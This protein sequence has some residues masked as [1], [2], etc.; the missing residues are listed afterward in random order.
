MIVRKVVLLLL[1]IVALL[2]AGGKTYSPR[3]WERLINLH[4]YA[5]P[6]SK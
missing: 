3:Q 2:R 5:A 4:H 6:R 1:L